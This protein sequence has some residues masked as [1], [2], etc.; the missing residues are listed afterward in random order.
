[1]FSRQQMVWFMRQPFGCV[2][3]VATR[4]RSYMRPSGGCGCWQCS[5]IRG[6]LVQN[7]SSARVVVRVESTTIVHGPTGLGGRFYLLARDAP[8][9]LAVRPWCRTWSR[10][11]CLAD[12]ILATRR[13]QLMDTRCQ[14]V[15]VV[16]YSWWCLISRPSAQLAPLRRSNLWV[17]R[18]PLRSLSQMA[19]CRQDVGLA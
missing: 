12:A 3:A 19:A 1:L 10:L 8:T 11:F 15:G 5:W 14:N 9:R 7:P 17:C 16:A 4:Y 6:E 2:V 18:L 13:C